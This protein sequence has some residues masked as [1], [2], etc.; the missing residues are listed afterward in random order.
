MTYHNYSNM[1]ADK[2]II[3]KGC[4]EAGFLNLLR[5]YSGN[6]IPTIVANDSDPTNSIDNWFTH[7]NRILPDENSVCLLKP[8][9]SYP[10]KFEDGILLKYS[11]YQASLDY[12]EY[13]DVSNRPK[14]GVVYN[15][16]VYTMVSILGLISNPIS[17][18][19]Y[20]D[21]Y[22]LP[23][24]WLF[25]DHITP[26]AKLGDRFKTDDREKKITELCM[27]EHDDLKKL[28][29]RENNIKPLKRG[30]NIEPLSTDSNRQALQ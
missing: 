8:G 28:E 11:N 16:R 18:Y 23:K 14:Y 24:S 13:K 3:G 5:L 4:S 9:A 30:N 17:E 25:S 21:S 22:I 20:F 19:K 7:I 6:Y 29:Y 1:P 15:D 10:K 2:I 27:K 12:K 26:D